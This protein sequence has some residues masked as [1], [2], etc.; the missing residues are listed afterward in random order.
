[1]HGAQACKHGQR[2]T[3]ATR[4]RTRSRGSTGGGMPLRSTKRL[5]RHHGASGQPHS[6]TGDERDAELAEGHV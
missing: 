3:N 4:P 6:H 2:S 5:E 1:M